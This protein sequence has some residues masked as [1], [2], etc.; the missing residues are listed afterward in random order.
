MDAKNEF[1]FKTDLKNTW[2][3]GCGYFG[4]L[5]ALQKALANLKIPN[6]EA[7]FVSGIGCS[8]RTAGFVNV[9][10]M[11]ALHGR[12]IPFARGIELA[13]RVL[14]KKNP[15]WPDIPVIAVGGDGDLFS[16]GAQHLPHAVRSGANMTVIM[17][18]NHVYALTKGQTSPTTPKTVC[19]SRQKFGCNPPVDPL[20]DILAFG[21][22]SNLFLAQGI[23]NDISH[24]TDIIEQGI[25]YDGFSFISI[26]SFCVSFN[27]KDWLETLKENV[28]LLEPGSMV[29]LPDGERFPHDPSDWFKAV[30]ILKTPLGV[31]PYLGVIYKR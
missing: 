16:I 5:A 18:D 30:K 27:E 21:A 6:H 19:E 29:E 10:A 15:G 24:L 25:K 2:C 7:A 9:Y 8:G 31:K 23:C 11:N 4:N 12:A 17:F 22:N 13:Q 28:Y 26:Q 1:N 3:P 20:L 14:K